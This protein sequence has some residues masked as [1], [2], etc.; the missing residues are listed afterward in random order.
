MAEAERGVGRDGNLKR[1]AFGGQ[2]LF[3]V[4]P[5]TVVNV[6]QS[7]PVAVFRFAPEA[8]PHLPATGFH[9]LGKTSLRRYGVGFIRPSLARQLGRV[10]TNQ[11]D[12][13]AIDQ[14]QGVA[15]DDVSDFIGRKIARKRAGGM[16]GETQQPEKEK[17]A[18]Q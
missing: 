13:S 18:C 8:Q 16:K 4:A 1:Q 10:K 17:G 5:A 9:Q 2:T 15:I 12:A 14:T 7:A 6:G 3:E 11:T